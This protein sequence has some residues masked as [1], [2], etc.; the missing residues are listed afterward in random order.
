MITLTELNKL[1]VNATF[2]ED[3]FGWTLPRSTTARLYKK[4]RSLCHEDKVTDDNKELARLTFTKLQILWYDAVK[5]YEGGV[6]G[7]KSKFSV[8]NTD[9]VIRNK[10]TEYRITGIQP[11]GN[12]ANT[13]ISGDNTIIK[14]SRCVGDNKF[15][16]NEAE[17]LE[18]IHCKDY[19]FGLDC[20]SILLESFKIKNEKKETLIVNVMDKDNEYINLQ[21]LMDTL[22]KQGRVLDC[23]HIIWIWKRLLSIIGVIH[24]AGY[25]H[26]A[27]VPSN[28]LINPKNH[29]VKIVDFCYSVKLGDTIKVIDSQ[30]KEFYP[31]EIE[32]GMEVDTSFD[33]FMIG[34]IMLFLIGAN[35]VKVID[36][37]SDVHRLMENM[38]RSS[39]IRNKSSRMKNAWCFYDNIDE[40]G[41]Q[42]YGANKFVELKL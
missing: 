15:L 42:L 30:Y 27:L 9:F 17:I 40:L 20:I 25:V 33:I 3:V 2:A 36:F 37:P 5:R 22:T 41:Q 39:V 14:V 18:D 8:T 7:D 21:E 32:S 19:E 13:Y 26:G 38:I 24:Q 10:K 34:K 16:Q 12:L 23:R 11:H 35:V 4:Y 28:V 31:P 6:Y 1:V 29:G